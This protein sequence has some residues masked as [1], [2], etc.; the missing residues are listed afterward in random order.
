VVFTFALFSKYDMHHRT[1]ARP[2]FDYIQ[3]WYDS[4]VVGALGMF[5][6]LFPLAC[7]VCTVLLSPASLQPVRLSV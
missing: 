6:Y 4:V 5:F 7:C 2:T 1:Q 3:R